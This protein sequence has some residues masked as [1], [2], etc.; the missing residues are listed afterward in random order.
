MAGS[1]VVAKVFRPTSNPVLAPVRLEGVCGSST[2]TTKLT[3]HLPD[4]FL[5]IVTEVGS[6][7][8]GLDQT[9]LI[10]IRPLLVASCRES[11]LFVPNPLPETLNPVLVHL[12]VEYPSLALLNLGRQAGLDLSKNAA[13]DLYRSL[14]TCCC[15]TKRL[16]C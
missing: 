4:L 14:I 7:G 16:F 2:S 8:S 10:S 1:S 15:E 13:I 9:T 5:Y 11:S 3:Y 6:F 12:A